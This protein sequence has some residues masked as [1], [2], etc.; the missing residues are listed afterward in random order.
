MAFP[1]LM[2]HFMKNQL[3]K[4]FVTC[5][6]LFFLGL[7]ITKGD[8]SSDVYVKLV[9]LSAPK[10]TKVSSEYPGGSYV[11]RNLVD[12]DPRTE[13]SSNGNGTNTIVEFSFPQPV[14]LAGF[15]HQDRNDPATVAASELVFMDHSGAIV[16]REQIQHKNK[17][18][19]V[20]FCAFSSPIIAQNVRW[21]ITKLG[22]DRHG[23]VG[24]AEISF[25]T[26][27]EPEKLPLG[28][29]MEAQTFSIVY[30]KADIQNQPLKLTID[31]PYTKPIN[32][33]LSVSGLKPVDLSL[34]LGSQTL[35]LSLP[36]TETNRS[37]AASIN[38]GNSTLVTRELIVPVP[39]KLKVYILPH[40]HTD[41]GYTE[42]QTAI[43][44]RQVQNLVDGIAY[45]KKTSHYP[46][47]AR[48]IWNV[49][50]T[51]AADL[52]LKRLNEQ[53]R[54]DFFEAVKTGQVSL[55]GMYLNEL[56]GLCRP[57]E[58]IRLF[59][60]STKLADQCSTTIDSAMISDV[61][62]YTWGTVTAM[63]QAGIKYFSVAPNYF[64]RIGT[65]L[66]EWENKP[67]YWIGPDGKSKVLVWIPYRGY[68]LSHIINKLS[69]EFVADYVTQLEKANY[70][71]DVIY[72]RWSGHGDNAV[73]DPAICEFVKEWNEKNSW[74]QFVIS[75]TSDAFKDF[76]SRY[77]STLPEVRGDWTPYWEDGAGSSALETGMNRHSSD[78]LVQAETLFALLNPAAYPAKDF[79]DAWNSVLL[80]SEHTWGAWC[81]ISGPSRKETLE[82]WEIKKS[83]A[84][85]ADRQS[86][87]LLQRATEMLKGDPMPSQVD[88]LNTT[89]WERTETVILSP[90]L[91]RAGD[92]VLDDTGKPV[93]S[94]RLKNG[95]LMFMAKS[96]PA[97]S[98]KRYQVVS[99]TPHV[100]GK[101]AAVFD[102]MENE[103]ILLKV[104]RKTGSIRKF[105][106]KGI[107]GDFA[108]PSSSHGINEY[109]Y[110]I[111]DNLQ[112]L[113]GVSQVK[114][115]VYE[116][117]P[118]MASMVIDS[119]APGCNKLSCEIRLTAGCDYVE[120]WNLVDK[121]KIE[122]SNYYAN[123]GKESVN[124]AYPFN[125]PEGQMWLDL[126]LGAMRPELDQMPSACKDW[127]TVGRGG[128]VSGKDRGI[129]WISLDAP[130]VQVGGIT[131]RLL[132]SQTN[133]EVWRKKVEPTQKLYC[134]AMNNH[135]GT[136]YRAYQDGPVWFRFVLRPFHQQEPAEF[137]RF[138]IRFSQPLLPVPA[139][140][141]IEAAQSSLFQ[142]SSPDIIVIGFKPADDGKGWIVRLFN[143]SGKETA[144]RFECKL[145]KSGKY[146]LSD[147]REHSITNISNEITV[148]S[149][150]LVTLRVE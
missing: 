41:I 99:G 75:S 105:I 120:I 68:A 131:A 137:Q 44:A 48:F 134:W 147:T 123:E 90:E 52:Y 70:P 150:G 49:E 21:R 83:Y 28:I 77:G 140:G 42:I 132:N 121:K 38:F 34:S 67:F 29:R 146:W 116:N 133:P 54:N 50:V 128:W 46:M 53:Q 112:N 11:V 136:N 6:I 93:M 59:R 110:L 8:E 39:K 22:P 114:V 145:S 72:M 102:T 65:I 57:E 104:N 141:K 84:D 149:W 3:Q 12:G 69:P 58:L 81:S 124:F 47:G 126:P 111:G 71:Y 115:K 2:K 63:A 89:S 32:A 7:P 127:F 79:E 13:F 118:L 138:A 19:G 9:P 142:F 139:R 144:T 91:S 117:G 92:R 74:P 14:N 16:G 1:I 98:S 17:R 108:D 76:E 18:G 148:P 82:Q 100:E 88:V 135:W 97:F 40:S 30:G 87:S 62:G 86:R 25:Y 61:P 26:K 125:V 73:P 94:Q 15:R 4:L 143:A 129:A 51:W 45:A 33:Q 130:L 27:G 95:H 31:Y 96:V 24:G 80:Y 106:G 119:E 37:I 56:T 101:A 23:T 103:R 60:Y 122:A 64:D 55:Q 20:T 66:K 10:I 36:L 107:E 109:L 5:I 113:R 43:E 35:Q 78:R 85:Q